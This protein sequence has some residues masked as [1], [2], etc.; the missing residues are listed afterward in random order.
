MYQG[1]GKYLIETASS[2]VWTLT[3]IEET[4][5][6]AHSA[7]TQRQRWQR[8]GETKGKHT[9]YRDGRDTERL[10]AS[11]R[12]TEMAETRRGWRQ[13]HELQ[14]W[15]RHGEAEGKHTNYRGGRDTE[16]LKASTQTTEMA[17]TRRGWRQAHKIHRCRFC[18]WPQRWQQRWNGAG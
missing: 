17:E 3:E 8:H 11:T 5:P 16:R 13:A 7:T 9:N 12:N 1:A 15:Q 18:W 14:R 6:N 2:V 10:K 4:D